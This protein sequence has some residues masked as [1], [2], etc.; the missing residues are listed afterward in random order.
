MK[1]HCENL[2]PEDIEKIKSMANKID[3]L[4]KFYQSLLARL[5][6]PFFNRE[7]ITPLEILLG[8]MKVISGNVSDGNRE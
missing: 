1:C 7:P 5:E 3:E 2:S 4:G 8:S 6:T